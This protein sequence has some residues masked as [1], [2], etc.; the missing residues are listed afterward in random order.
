MGTTLP[1]EMKAGSA[2]LMDAQ[3]TVSTSIAKT[4]F[5]HSGIQDTRSHLLIMGFVFTDGCRGNRS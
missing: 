5:L 2:L 1:E 3:Q 4:A